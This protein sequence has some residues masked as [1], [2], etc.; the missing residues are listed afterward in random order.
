MNPHQSRRDWFVT[1]SVAKEATRTRT[2]TKEIDKYSKISTY[3]NMCW[4][5]KS[6][7]SLAFAIVPPSVVS[8]FPLEFLLV[9]PLLLQYL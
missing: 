6:Y 7:Q 9:G 5:A 1:D 8:M 3:I 4:F 2:R